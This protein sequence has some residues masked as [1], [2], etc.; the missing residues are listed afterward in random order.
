MAS[1]SRNEFPFSTDCISNMPFICEFEVFPDL[2]DLQFGG[3]GHLFRFFL[4]ADIFVLQTFWSIHQL[5][6]DMLTL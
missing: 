5:L 3:D 4:H 2:V 1:Q 6:T